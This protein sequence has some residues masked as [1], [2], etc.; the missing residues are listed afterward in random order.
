MSVF[1]SLNQ[2]KKYTK[3]QIN[4]NHTNKQGKK[5]KPKRNNNNK[6]IQPKNYC[7]LLQLAKIANINQR[8]I[9]HC[10]Y[11]HK[12]IALGKL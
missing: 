6:K 5:T 12:T 4:K 10:A 11:M 8:P 7:L 1:F 9:I 2:K 3:I